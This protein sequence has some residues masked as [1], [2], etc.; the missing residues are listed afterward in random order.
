MRSGEYLDAVEA[1]L[2]R[3]TY[4]ERADV[5]RELT[6]HIEDHTEALRG[7]GCTEDEADERAAEAMGDP[8]ETGR[9]IAKL[10][11][12]IWLWIERIAAVIIVFMA[13]WAVLG[14]GMLGMAWSSISAR[15]CAPDDAR[16][17]RVDE[18]MVIG[19]DVLRVYGVRRYR[20]RDAFEAE[21]WMCAYDR[22]P[23]G[24]VSH[25]IWSWTGLYAN[26]N[27][28]SRKLNF[29]GGGEGGTGAT[30]KQW[31]VP[32][33]AGDTSLTLR[34]ER[35]GVMVERTFALPEVET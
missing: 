34:Y 27:G 28:E 14:F 4:R 2:G 30:Y 13:V 9:A 19:D 3:L 18:R 24:V 26:G 31:V 16:A 21:L 32:L 29:S 12:P 7:I 1:E 10:Y 15:F 6:A 20:T 11:R 5:R 33:E 23:L 35:F 22:V 17:V 25:A 8:A